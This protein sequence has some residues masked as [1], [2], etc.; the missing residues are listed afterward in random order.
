MCL[1][2]VFFPSYSQCLK[3]LPLPST[4]YV[5]GS[6]IKRQETPWAQLFPLRLQLRLG[7]EYRCEL[8]C[9]HIVEMKCLEKIPTFHRDILAAF[10]EIKTLYD[11]NKNGDIILFNNREILVE[12]KPAFIREWFA[13]G[14]LTIKDIL[15]ESSRYLKFHEFQSKYQCK[16]IF[17]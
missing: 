1:T 9:S 6:L 15:N 14:I 3:K 8:I 5:V 2:T 11:C 10:H 4:P 7:A 16:T 12:G 13:K 17:L